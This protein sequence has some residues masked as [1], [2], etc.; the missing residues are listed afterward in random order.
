MIVSK[1]SKVLMA[2]FLAVGL[3]VAAPLAHAQ[4]EQP[5]TP[6]QA[7][8]VRKIIRD[9][10]I[11]HP[12]V[13]IDA[14]E[15]LREKS[16]VEA[17]AD[18]KKTVL[19]RK[20]E[21]FNV[22]NDPVYGNPAG[23]VVVVEFFDYNCPYCKVV[24]EPLLDAVKADG[25]VKLVFKEMPILSADS[26]IASRMALAALKQGKYEEV[27]RGLM[28]SRGK[29]DKKAILRI[30]AEA[31]VNVEQAEKEML[32]SEMDKALRKGSEL[33]HATGIASTPAFI[34]SNNSGTS[35]KV[36]NGAVEGKIFQQIFAS[37]RKG[38]KS[39]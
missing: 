29:L 14:V 27:H 3:G 31:G 28:K 20:D 22:V 30:A 25:K 6:K 26:E 35:V 1:V 13:I 11:E 36:L 19:S 4:E 32:T 33:A 5:F 2:V 16:Q 23:D 38:E 8:A 39:Q 34:I 7:D 17:E 18:A 21:F 37:I 12:E 9:Y 24:T 10:L 15:A